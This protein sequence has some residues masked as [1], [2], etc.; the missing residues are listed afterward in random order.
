MIGVDTPA[1]GKKPNASS[2]PLKHITLI[3]NQSN[4]MPTAM[5]HHTVSNLEFGWV[6]PFI[7]AD[8]T[9]TAFFYSVI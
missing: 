6:E 1:R 5:F 7:E 4:R 2:S 9:S 8:R 3:V